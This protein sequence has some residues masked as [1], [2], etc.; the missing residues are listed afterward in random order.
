MKG[1]IEEPEWKWIELI[2]ILQRCICTISEG[3]MSAM[4]PLS[5]HAWKTEIQGAYQQSRTKGSSLGGGRGWMVGTWCLD[6]KCS[7]QLLLLCCTS[8]GGTA[9]AVEGAHI[10]IYCS[11][12]PWPKCQTPLMKIWHI[13]QRVSTVQGT[14]KPA[15]ASQSCTISLFISQD[16]CTIGWCAAKA[17]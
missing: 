6:A 14:Q 9:T 4:Y 16:D 3:Q 17:S 5:L 1:H 7:L 15:A 13:V 2:S 11:R 8:P 10:R 12:R